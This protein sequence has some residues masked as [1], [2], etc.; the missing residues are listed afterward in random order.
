MET[1]EGVEGAGYHGNARDTI[2]AI[3]HQPE[4]LHHTETWRR[5][6]ATLTHEHQVK[7]GAGADLMVTAPHG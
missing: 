3:L 6:A 7:L 2:V 1:G 4:Q 5:M